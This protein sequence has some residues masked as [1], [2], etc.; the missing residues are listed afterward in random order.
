LEF[1][2]EIRK[3]LP[4]RNSQI[5]IVRAMWQYAEFPWNLDISIVCLTIVAIP[6]FIFAPLWKF[7]IFKFEIKNIRNLA[8]IENSQGGKIINFCWQKFINSNPARHV[9]L[10]W[11][12]QLPMPFWNSILVPK[13]TGQCVAECHPAHQ[14]DVFGFWA[15]R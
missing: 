5:Q 1:K 14:H 2:Q 9:P 15:A 4:F 6:I 8:G 11:I 13:Q 10:P 12:L 3:Y 7:L